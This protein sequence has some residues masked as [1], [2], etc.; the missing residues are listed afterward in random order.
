[1]LI[2]YFNGDSARK[3]VDRGI[4]TQPFW[5][6][7]GDD[8]RIPNKQK[9]VELPHA[10][11]GCQEYE[12]FADLIM[13]FDY[14][15]A[16]CKAG[17]VYAT[18]LI[19]D[20][21][22]CLKKLSIGSKRD[23]TSSFFRF[24][25]TW[26]HVLKKNSTCLTTLAL[27]YVPESPVRQTMEQK[28]DQKLRGED[29]GWIRWQNAPST[30]DPCIFTHLV[31]KAECVISIRRCPDSFRC[32]IA[33]NKFCVLYDFR[34]YQQIC[35][36][37]G[38]TSWVRAVCF[39]PDGKYAL[40][41]S[42]DKKGKVWNTQTAE[43]CSELSGHLSWVVDCDWVRTDHM[44]LTVSDDGTARIWN[45][46]FGDLIAIH[47]HHGT[48]LKCGRFSPSGLEVVTGDVEGKIM[49]WGVPSCEVAATTRLE[50]A[51][52]CIQW[53][54]DGST[55]AAASFSGQVVLLNHDLEIMQS[56]EGRK[57]FI[58]RDMSS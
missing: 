20:Y 40:S 43:Q 17:G 44:V 34:S 47:E 56:F 32:A 18:S 1:M 27:N 6:F 48:A 39:S 23:D 38:H 14:I 41:V 29:G 11:M 19:E 55:I 57:G 30:I 31:P 4:S 10:I 26:F 35:D 24:I 45:P 28:W 49:L 15:E 54:R 3:F 37:R 5:F 42:N 58:P 16:K 25:S 36:F 33:G 52:H 2:E 51:V 9:L 21:I 12:E 13:N 46:Y 22:F 50:S 7:A 53:N 8:D